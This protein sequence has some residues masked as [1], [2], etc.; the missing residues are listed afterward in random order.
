MKFEYIQYIVGLAFLICSATIL[1]AQQIAPHTYWVQFADKEG[2]G[3]NLG[4]PSEFLSERAL[5]RRARHSVK[6]D[7]SDLP[8]S[9]IYLDSLA[10]FN[11]NIKNVSKWMNGAVIYCTD[12]ALLD[13][14]DKIGFI[15]NSIY[16]ET[17]R[18]GI[19]HRDKFRNEPDFDASLLKSTLAD[20]RDMLNGQALHSAGFKGE[21]MLIAI[22]DGG[23]DNVDKIDEFKYLYE[24][25]Q[26]LLARDFV[27]DGKD[28]YG[29]TSYHGTMVLSI[30]AVDDNDDPQA[31][32][33]NADFMLLRTENGFS[34]Y[35]VE[36][37]NW[38]SAAELADSMGA[39]II[40]I[41]L[42]YSLFDD[43]SQ[44][45][46]YADMDGKTTTISKAVTIA[47]RKGMLVVNSAGNSGNDPWYYITAPADAD[48]ILTIG[49]VDATENLTGFSSHGPTA[50]GRVKPDVCA[51]GAQNKVMYPTGDFVT[52][53][54]TS[55]S[56]PV[57]A[58]MAACLWQSRPNA[59]CWQVADAIRMSADRYQNPNSD[60]GYGIPKFDKARSILDS[61]YTTKNPSEGLTHF[62]ISPNPVNQ[63][64]MLRINVPWLTE[65]VNATVRIYDTQGRLL[66]EYSSTVAPGFNY[67]QFWNPSFASFETGMYYYQLWV[68]GRQFGLSFL[69]R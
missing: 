10:S 58:G 36:E 43:A 21:G 41:S 52:G 34:E 33:P 11:L 5:L 61:I 57:I 49:A 22:T 1:S 40:N 55:F 47:S 68:K 44:D 7:V 62:G 46:T 4:S 14:L 50:D 18:I 65:T 3:F 39:D 9:K 35:R 54:G 15:A 6:I 56:S 38:V 59:T 28:I 66:D 17:Q 60:Y 32:A 42:G 63:Q 64:T 67:S 53:S 23:F 48:S 31:A 19:Q 29:N 24:N 27:K 12:A 16:P 26:V 2:N 8:V 13:T 20:Q 25:N 69:I 30:I 51:L 37:Y 45:Y